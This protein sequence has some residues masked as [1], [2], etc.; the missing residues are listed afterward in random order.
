MTATT[1][2]LVAR[3][4][5]TEQE[6]LEFAKF[7]WWSEQVMWSDGTIIENTY[8]AE[9]YITDFFLRML[10]S[11]ISTMVKNR[12]LAKLDAQRQMIEQTIE[13]KVKDNLSI[14]IE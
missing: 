9:Q 6:I 14:D 8:S 5:F 3:A 1:K 2:T 11:E 12:E 4:T 10:T 7:K 13:N